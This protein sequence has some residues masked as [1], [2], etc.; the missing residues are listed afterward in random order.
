MNG[1]YPVFCVDFCVGVGVGFGAAVVAGV[2]FSGS[3]G[4]VLL[5]GLEGLINPR[6]W[7]K[8]FCTLY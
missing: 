3:V 4:S 1:H 5:S 8:R 2:G 6:A 7:L